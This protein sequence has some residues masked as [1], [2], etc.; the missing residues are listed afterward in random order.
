MNRSKFAQITFI[1]RQ[2]D[3]GHVGEVCHKAR[4]SEDLL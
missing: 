3:E 1:L 4:I 2:A